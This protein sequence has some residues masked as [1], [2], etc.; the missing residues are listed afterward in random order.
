[1]GTQPP[2]GYP[3]KPGQPPPPP[4]LPADEAPLDQP[5]D[6]QTDPEVPQE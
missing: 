2:P 5:Q 1:M 6:E 4:K 3:P